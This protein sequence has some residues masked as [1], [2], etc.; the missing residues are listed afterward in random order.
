MHI[1]SLG[2]SKC[3]KLHYDVALKIFFSVTNS[4]TDF[5]TESSLSIVPDTPNSGIDTDTD[6][7]LIH[8]TSDGER[9]NL[10]FDHATT[11]NELNPEDTSKKKKEGYESNVPKRSICQYEGNCYRLIYFFF[12]NFQ[13]SVFFFFFYKLLFL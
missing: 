11:S 8:F 12:N 6:A 13:N 2:I 9:S 5:S 10:P 4:C 3:Y 1:N 7:D